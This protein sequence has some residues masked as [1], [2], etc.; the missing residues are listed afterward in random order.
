MEEEDRLAALEIVRYPESSLFAGHGNEIGARN[1]AAVLFDEKPVRDP[2]VD[3]GEA[4]LGYHTV[5]KAPAGRFEIAPKEFLRKAEALKPY[6]PTATASGFAQW[7]YSLYGTGLGDDADRQTGKD[8]EKEVWERRQAKLRKAAASINLNSGWELVHNGLHLDQ[9]EPTWFSLPELRVRREAL[10][11]SPD[12]LFA[13]RDTG[14]VIIVEIKNTRM[15]VPPNLWPNVWAQLW[16]YSQLEIA[17]K[18]STVSVIGEVWGEMWHKKSSSP[19][20]FLRASVR[21]DPRKK[22]Y[23]SFFRELFNIYSGTG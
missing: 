3:Q 12:L 19:T 4:F 6:K 9:S 2:L 21:R 15:V 22:A 1:R 18:A 23:D 7:V 13:N 17:R 14:A 20:V 10:R 8:V 11:L 16:C 5:H